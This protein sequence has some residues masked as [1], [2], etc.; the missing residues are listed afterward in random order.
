[1]VYIIYAYIEAIFLIR[2]IAQYGI[3]IE[4]LDINTSNLINT[5]HKTIKQFVTT[6]EGNI[7]LK[8]LAKGLI[9]STNDSKTRKFLLIV[10]L[11]SCS[12]LFK[13]QDLTFV[14]ILCNLQIMQQFEI[15]TYL[16]QRNCGE[17]NDFFSQYSYLSLFSKMVR[18]FME[19]Q[20]WKIVLLYHKRKDY[21]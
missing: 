16:R 14:E 21:L 17:L 20:C 10:L 1:M 9:S 15:N 7:I 11:K 6:S 3:C 18:Q 19:A 13:S 8:S 12:S 5:T 2:L 4:M